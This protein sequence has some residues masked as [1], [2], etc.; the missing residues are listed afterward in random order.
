MPHNSI[1][2]ILERIEPSF[3]RHLVGLLHVNKML[4]TNESCIIRILINFVNQ[5]QWKSYPCDGTKIKL[6]KKLFHPPRKVKRK[7]SYIFKK[8]ETL[9]CVD[10]TENRC[11]MKMEP[12][13]EKSKEKFSLNHV[14]HL[15]Y[16]TLEAY[17]D[18][19]DLQSVQDTWSTLNE[20]LLNDDVMETECLPISNCYV[21]T[22]TLIKKYRNILQS[23]KELIGVFS[24]L[25][26]RKELPEVLNIFGNIDLLDL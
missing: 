8:C 12:K 24:D 5:S 6:S 22:E 4:S 17:L 15:L 19:Y 2:R 3:M 14:V 23:I 21:V 25:K 16:V 26:N 18:A 10:D 20:Q 1:I 7:L 11:Y 9:P 13:L